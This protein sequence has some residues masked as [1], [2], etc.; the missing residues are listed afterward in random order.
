M[1]ARELQNQKKQPKR[2]TMQPV[3]KPL[4][5]NKLPKPFKTMGGQRLAATDLIDVSPSHKVIFVWRDGQI[6]TDRAFYG[7]LLKT[8]GDGSLYPLM[9]MHW[10][11]SHKGLHIRTPCRSEIDYTNRQLPGAIELD[12]RTVS[13]YDPQRESDRLELIGKFCKAAG[14]EL[15]AEGALC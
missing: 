10:H 11:P 3:F 12:I 15:G 5:K 4:K 2:L 14:I 9:E 13:R 6:L 8:V 7:W 1:D